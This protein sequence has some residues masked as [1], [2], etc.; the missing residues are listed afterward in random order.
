MQPYRVAIVDPDELKRHG[1]T[2]MMSTD[3]RWRLVLSTDDYSTFERY[4]KENPVNIA[5]LEDVVSPLID[6]WGMLERW[7]NVSPI[8]H[9]IVLSQNLSTRHIQRLFSTG[10]LGYIHR[11]DCTKETLLACLTTVSRNQAY[12]SPQASAELYKR[13]AVATEFGLRK[14]DIDVLKC[15]QGGLNTQEIAVQLQLDE[16]SVY[17]S[18]N[19]LRK[20]LDVRTNEQLIPAAMRSGLLDQGA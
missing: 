4:L 10:V 9:I 2:H 19:R 11:P 7:R 5:I 17:R 15:I 12:V 18:R 6:L 20:A 13:D 8:L 14:T 16:R 3:S 1:L